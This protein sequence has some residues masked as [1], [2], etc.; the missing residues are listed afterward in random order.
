[1]P[2]PV[3]VAKD[4]CF[5][6]E[7]TQVLAGVDLRLEEGEALAIVGPNGSGKTTLLRVLA[8]LEAASSG[9]IALGGTQIGRLRPQARTQHGLAMA[10]GRETVFGDLSVHDNLVAGGYLLW[11]DPQRLAQRLEAVYDLFPQLKNVRTS[12]GVQLSGGEQHMVSL[13]KAV[14]LEPKVL[15]VDELS[16]G[17]A[18]IL[19]K[20][21]MEGISALVEMGTS[22]ILV[23]QSAQVAGL[24]A[25]RSLYLAR[26]LLHSSPPGGVAV[27]A[28]Q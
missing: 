14:L 3:L 25:T 20:R 18:P 8:G 27:G 13:A 10:F 4:L 15:C 23:E 5:S 9:E 24:V 19:V 26:G 17:L 12:L 11:R 1:M 7:T 2:E 21:L 22:I 28:V 6:Y 16:L